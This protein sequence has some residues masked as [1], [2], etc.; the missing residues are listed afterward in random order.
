[1]CRPS[2]DD[3]SRALLFRGVIRSRGYLLNTGY[4][5]KKPKRRRIK[6]WTE[7]IINLHLGK[8]LPQV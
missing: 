1:M 2:H 3:W 8:A 7:V 6:H 4:L 5:Q